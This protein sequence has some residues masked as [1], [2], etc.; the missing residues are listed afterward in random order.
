MRGDLEV[1][2][3][4]ELLI[5]EEHGAIIVDNPVPDPFARTVECAHGLIMMVIVESF[6]ARKQTDQM[7]RPDW[8][9]QMAENIDAISGGVELNG[10]ANDKTGMTYRGQDQRPTSGPDNQI[11]CRWNEQMQH[12]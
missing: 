4:A 12:E 2:Y 1:L 9:F 8:R 5:N 11:D 7:V 10:A 3:P 6:A